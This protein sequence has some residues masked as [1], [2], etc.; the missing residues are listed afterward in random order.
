MW[1]GGPVVAYHMGLSKSIIMAYQWAHLSNGQGLGSQN[2]SYDA[3]GFALRL[4]N[5]F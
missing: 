5:V 1:R 3:E 2:T 4:M